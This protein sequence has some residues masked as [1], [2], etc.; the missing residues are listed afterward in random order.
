[1][2]R[3]GRF[4]LGGYRDGRRRRPRLAQMTAAAV[5]ATLA[6]GACG[7]ADK[8]LSADS[9]CEDFLSTEQADQVRYVRA[10][11]EAN[12]ALAASGVDNPMGSITYYCGTNPDRTIGS[13]ETFF[14]RKPSE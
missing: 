11:L 13:L 7:A 10:R 14:D 1:M 5:V 12:G 4:G 3:T 9:T 6:V 2:N 8:G